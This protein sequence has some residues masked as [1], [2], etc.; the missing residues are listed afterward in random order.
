INSIHYKDTSVTCQQCSTVFNPQVASVKGKM[1]SCKCCGHSFQ[2]NKIIQNIRKTP[3][4]RMYAKLVLLKNGVKQ[5]LTV[6]QYDIDLYKVTVKEL[7][8]RDNFYPVVSIQPGNNTNQIL[9]YYYHYWHEMFNERQLLC[10]GI[11]AERIKKIED[12]NIRDLF[13]CLFSGVL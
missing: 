11:L 12:I 6:K 9:N 3:S 10:L 4:H 8:Q 5:Y 1:A 7:S 13:I 2:I